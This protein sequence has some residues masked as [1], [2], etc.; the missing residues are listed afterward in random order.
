MYV[1]TI[2]VEKCQ[3]CGDCVDTCPSEMLALA[4]EGGKKYAMMKGSV[5]DCLGCFSCQET[6]EEGAITVTEM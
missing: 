3:A 2:D 4:E 5:D 6:C 1:I